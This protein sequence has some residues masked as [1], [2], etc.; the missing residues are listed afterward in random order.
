MRNGL[1]M[2]PR[3]AVIAFG[4][5]SIFVLRT[6]SAEGIEK[7]CA[8]VLTDMR[9]IGVQLGNCDLACRRKC[10]SQLVCKN[11]LLCVWVVKR[12]IPHVAVKTL[13]K[14]C[15]TEFLERFGWREDCESFRVTGRFAAFT[16]RSLR[17]CVRRLDIGRVAHRRIR[18]RQSG[19]IEDRTDVLH[20]TG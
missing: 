16:E 7:V 18:S 2:M 19:N 12:Y 8:G 13:V 14:G 15:G 20:N 4:L 1:L 6:A 5:V 9:V 17:A 10:R 3:A 11:C